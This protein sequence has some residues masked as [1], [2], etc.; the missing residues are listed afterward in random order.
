MA[1]AEQLKI[2]QKIDDRVAAVQ[3][4]VE[5]TRADEQIVHRDLQGVGHGVQAIDNRVQGIDME[6][7]DIFNKVQGVDD[8]FDRETRSLS[9][10]FFLIPMALTSSQA[11]G[12][13]IVYFDGFAPQTNLPTIS[14]HARLVTAAP[15]SGS[16]K[17]VFSKSGNP[18]A[19]FCG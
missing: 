5:G 10:I 3:R 11:T 2:A 19:L 1:S 12:L 13:E 6:V 14:L 8:K 18:L 17:E 7:K 4:E 15:H 16:F 9:V